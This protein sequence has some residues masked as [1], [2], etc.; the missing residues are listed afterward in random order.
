MNRPFHHLIILWCKI[1]LMMITFRLAR[2][3]I[4]NLLLCMKDFKVVIEHHTLR[5]TSNMILKWNKWT[6]PGILWNTG[7]NNVMEIDVVKSWLGQRAL[8]KRRENLFG[9]WRCFSLEVKQKT[10]TFDTSF[11]IYCITTLHIWR[12][13][14]LVSGNRASCAVRPESC[15]EDYLLPNI[16]QHYAVCNLFE[17]LSQMM[18]CSNLSV[19]GNTSLWGWHMMGNTWE[20]SLL[21]STLLCL[22][23]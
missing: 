1:G 7:W 10:G 18:E 8:E 6:I 16:T 17:I 4:V 9:S 23:V 21:Y 15:W 13:H 14:R 12:T 11:F 20:L 19:N 5:T 2:L 3:A 22:N